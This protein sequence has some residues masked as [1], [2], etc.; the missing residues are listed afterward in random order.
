MLFRS[1]LAKAF[2]AHVTAVCS[3]GAVDA[4]RSLGAD[5]VMDYTAADFRVT[6]QYDLILDVSA[7]LPIAQCKRALNPGGICVVAGY[8][9]IRHL[10]AVSLGGKSIVMLMAD[11]TRQNDLLV[12]NE[13]YETGKIKPL[14]DSSYPLTETAQALRRVETGHPKG[15]VVIRIGSFSE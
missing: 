7:T 11:N 4:V 1:Q 12:L 14:I 2:G 13:L 15:K 3:A 10:I 9:G 6:D 5:C 8:S